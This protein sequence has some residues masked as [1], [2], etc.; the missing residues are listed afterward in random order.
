MLDKDLTARI[1]DLYNIVEKVA[2]V[3][4]GRQ[5]HIMGEAMA[6]LNEIDA[7][8]WKLKC[9]EAERAEKA[10]PPAL[11]GQPSD[12]EGEPSKPVSGELK[13]EDL[14]KD[15]PNPGPRAFPSNRYPQ[16][17]TGVGDE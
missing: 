8:I 5:S 12:D 4:G 7:H 11:A 6:E 17:Q 14:G 16:L 15:E 3:G 1:S 10:P 9:E 13:D 2:N